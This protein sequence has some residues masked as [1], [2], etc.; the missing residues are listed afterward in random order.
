[1]FEKS[2][3]KN[4]ERYSFPE[5]NPFLVEGDESEVASIAYK[6]RKWD[7]GEG[8]N[9]IIR[10]EVDAVTSGA[11]D[12]KIFLSIKALNEWVYK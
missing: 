4:E 3:S 7:L 8:V 1:M 5:P 12:E 10:S 11:N 9:I 2:L 6:Y